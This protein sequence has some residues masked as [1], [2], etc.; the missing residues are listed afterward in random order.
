LNNEIKSTVAIVQAR[1]SSTRLKGKIFKEISGKPMLWHVLNRLSY[2][3]LID[4]IVVATT[5]DKEDDQTEEFCRANH[6]PYY[7]GSMEDVLARYYEAARVFNAG[8]IIR[9]TSDCPLIDPVIIDKMLTEYELVKDLCDY[10][11]NVVQRT[12]PR[13][14]DTEIFS[15]NAL[16]KASSEAKTKYERE[17]VTPFIYTNSALFKIKS[18]TSDVDYSFHRWTVDTEEDFKLVEAIY[19]YLYKPDQLFFLEDVIKLFDNDPGLIK[20]NQHVKQKLT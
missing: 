18:Y 11:S 2:S 16:E 1:Y 5:L 15:F 17:H 19:N 3:K 14:L 4:K 10:M 13:G 7:R 6:I 20:I 9:I 12:F 8:T